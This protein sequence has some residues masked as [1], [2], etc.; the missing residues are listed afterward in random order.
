MLICGNCL[1][2]IPKAS[3]ERLEREF[4]RKFA[5]MNVISGFQSLFVFT[6]NGG[7]QNIIH[8][9]KYR[10]AF[11]TSR[12]LGILTAKGLIKEIEKWHADYIIPVPIHKRRRA[13]RGYN[14]SFYLAKGIASVIKIPVR[15]GVLKRGRYTETQTALNLSERRENVRD[16]FII[17]KPGMAKGKRIILADDVI[18]TGATISECGSVL[19]DNGADRVFALSAAV[20]E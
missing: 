19:L 13:E 2:V 10:N 15:P 18:T 11:L 12:L 9:M 1:S 16:A 3:K 5:A 6:E 4:E 8:E 17:R 7:I 20:A 14:Q